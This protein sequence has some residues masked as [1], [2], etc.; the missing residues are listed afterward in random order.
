MGDG[1]SGGDPENR[2]QNPDSLL[3]K[4]LRL[5]VRQASPQSGD[6]RDRAPEPV[7]LQLRPRDEDLWIG[8]VGQGSIEEIDAHRRGEP[9]A[10]QLR[11]G[12]LRRAQQLR[13]QGARPGQ[14]RLQPVAQYTHD[15]GCTVTGGYV[16]RGERRAGAAGPLR[17]SATT[18]AARSGACRRRA[19]RCASSPSRCRSSRR[20]AR[21]STGLSSTPSRRPAPCHGSRHSLK[22][23]PAPPASGGPASAGAT[24]HTR[25]DW[26]RAAYATRV[27]RVGQ[28]AELPRH[29]QEALLGLE[30]AVDPL[31]LVGDPVEPL[32]KRVEL[33]VRDVT[34]FHRADLRARRSARA[35]LPGSRR[36]PPRD[37]G[38]RAVGPLRRLRSRPP[39]PVSRRRAGRARPPS[40][41][42][43]RP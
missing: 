15:D 4:M 19:A 24:A 40:A 1:G 7:A 29:L 14:A 16:Y 20:S 8:D 43:G 9:R 39:R 6:R 28:R 36:A 22:R 11:L 33:A 31:E 41:P 5:D 26:P 37:R 18:A 10:R 35:A 32:E 27:Q 13:G 34:A 25:G 2:A 17:R 38:A 21:A 3:G 23:L 42:R 12:R 30:S